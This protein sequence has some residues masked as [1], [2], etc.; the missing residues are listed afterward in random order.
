MHS[1][2]SN[3]FQ[4]IKVF[5]EYSRCNST[6]VSC[7][8]PCIHIWPKNWYYLLNR[9][10]HHF[11]RCSF[12]LIFVTRWWSSTG[13]IFFKKNTQLISSENFKSYFDKHSYARLFWTLFFGKMLIHFYQMMKP[14]SIENSI[15]NEIEFIF[16]SLF[17]FAQKSFFIH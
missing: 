7:Y 4:L 1:L 8:Y 11:Q 15:Q 5:A 12:A 13:M 17:S 2:W 9:I 14:R 16:N 3:N 10:Y 6:L